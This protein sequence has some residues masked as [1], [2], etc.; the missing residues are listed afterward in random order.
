M[1]TAENGYTWYRKYKSGGVEQGCNAGQTGTITLP[2]VMADSNYFISTRVYNGTN[3]VGWGE[4]GSDIA[5][6]TTTFRVGG[7]PSIW[8]VKGMAA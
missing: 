4:Y 6:T 3:N 7:L 2:V 1:P 5:R 8:E